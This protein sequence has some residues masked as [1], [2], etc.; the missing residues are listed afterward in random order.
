MAV[1]GVDGCPGGWVAARVDG[2]TVEWH[3]GRFADLLQ[4][5]AAVVGVDIPI[6]LP[7]DARRRAADVKARLLLGPQRSSVFFAPPRVVLEAA[8][9]REAT[10]LSRAAGSTG[11]SIQAFHLLTKI[12]EV[13]DL[14]R[15][16]LTAA[17]RVVEVH[18]ELSLHRLA[19]GPRLPGKRTLP[20]RLS[21]LDVLRRWLPALDLPA[22]LPAR[23]RPDD[24]LDA[25]AAAWSA[26]R[27]QRGE[28]QVLGG[29]RD[30]AGLPMRIV[31]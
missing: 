23:A 7:D 11:L 28:A 14:L 2:G 20:G 5:D 24:C 13:D 15:D 22:P 25:L 29:E 18:P 10:R 4:V 27:W 6:G 9:Q 31:V 16:D 12:A 19:G 26:M 21:R 1:L 3:A 17:A 8:S 30:G